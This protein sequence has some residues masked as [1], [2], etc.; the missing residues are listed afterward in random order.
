[1]TAAPLLCFTSAARLL[2][3]TTLGFLQ[4]V[5]P[6]GQFMLAVL[7]YGEVLTTARIITF[8]CIWIALAIFT[9]D[10]IRRSKEL[11]PASP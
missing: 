2:P 9:T 8:V 11:R 7:T 1:M 6:S 5:A 3:L 10:Q 4:Y